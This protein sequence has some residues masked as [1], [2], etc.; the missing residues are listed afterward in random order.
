MNVQQTAR[1]IAEIRELY[2]RQF[3][4]TE[5][6]V[7]VW[8]RYL[9]PFP[10]QAVRAALTEYLAE[11]QA[12]P[13][14]LSAL[15]ARL[16]Q[17][18]EGPSPELEAGEAWD[19]TLRFIRE[20]PPHREPAMDAK[21]PLLARVVRMVGGWTGLR[22]SSSEALLHQTRPHFLRLYAS[23][24]SQERRLGRLEAAGAGHLI[25]GSPRTALGAP[26][27]DAEGKDGL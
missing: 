11:D 17:F 12:F 8:H 9:E 3:E 25:A 23:L 18:S 7:E 2:P 10:P 6:T 13:P 26:R 19:K 15:L 14:A 27:I 22:A 16:R 4:P 1:L 24:A 21:Y 5:L 20:F